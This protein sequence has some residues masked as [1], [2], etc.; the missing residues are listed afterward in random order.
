MYIMFHPNSNLPFKHFCSQCLCYQ[1]NDCLCKLLHIKSATKCIYLSTK[2]DEQFQP[3][4]LTFQ[5]GNKLH[6]D[7]LSG[8]V[9]TVYIDKVSI[10]RIIFLH[11]PVRVDSN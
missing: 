9:F 10:L 5:L 3:R 2:I 4:F 1:S 11:M 6:V 8:N 7:I